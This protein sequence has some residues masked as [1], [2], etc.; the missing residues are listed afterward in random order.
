MNKRF[1]KVLAT[2]AAL[3]ASVAMM[4]GGASAANAASSTPVTITNAAGVTDASQVTYAK[5]GTVTYTPAAADSNY[6]EVTGVEATPATIASTVTSSAPSTMTSGK[7]DAR[8]VLNYVLAHGTAKEQQDFANAISS[9]A[10]T[11]TA[12]ATGSTI[13]LNDLDDDAVYVFHDQKG[14]SFLLLTGDATTKSL[15]GSALNTAALKPTTVPTPN[16][17]ISKITNPDGSFDYTPSTADSNKDGNGVQVQ[18]GDVVNYDVS[19]TVTPALLQAHGFVNDS[20]P[21]P[22]GFVDT[23]TGLKYNGITSTSAAGLKVTYGTAT[24]GTATY[25]AG[26]VYDADGN[27]TDAFKTAL[28]AHPTDG[29]VYTVSADGT[30]LHVYVDAAALAPSQLSYTSAGFTNTAATA[31][32]E[33]AYSATVQ[34][35]AAAEGSAADHHNS[36]SFQIGKDVSGTPKTIHNYAFTNLKINKQDV[37]SHAALA[38]AQFKLQVS[39]DGT[40]W[41]DVKVSGSNG[42]YNVAADQTA[43]NVPMVTTA[44]GLTV[45]GVGA[46]NATYRLVETQAAPGYLS[47][48]AFLPKVEFKTKTTEATAGDVTTTAYSIDHTSV[49]DDSKMGLVEVP[50]ADGTQVTIYNAKQITDL[51]KTGA[52]GITMFVVLG[53]LLLAV[54]IAVAVAARKAH[55]R[56]IAA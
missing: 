9:L 10:T 38:D 3:V 15:K 21:L 26:D 7:N 44:D 35:V 17:S 37:Q 55:N 43:A 46:E 45:N 28:A 32:L 6:A 13:T 51:P 27:L 42:V 12:A 22:V 5:L 2:A 47:S 40:T 30:S 34:N 56:A 54:A 4:I 53:L 49:T 16:K 24:L 31:K 23:M 11:N 18:N 50:A 1:S 20:T 36:A 41:N 8:M 14:Q 39:T 52:A 19:A 29:Y 25:Y 33:V 48:D